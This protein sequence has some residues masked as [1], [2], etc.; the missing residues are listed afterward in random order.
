MSNLIPLEPP[1]EEFQLDSRQQL[2]VKGLL[3][4]GAKE[5]AEAYKA[6]SLILSSPGF[7]SAVCLVAHLV[8]DI[9]N[10]LPA[11]S[12]I[13]VSA[14]FDYREALDDLARECERLGLITVPNT[15][16]LEGESS[17]IP[18]NYHPVEDEVKI[19]RH[20]LAKLWDLLCK[21]RSVGDTHGWRLKEMVRKADREQLPPSNPVVSS[22]GTQ[23]KAIHS[24]AQSE[25]HLRGPSVTNERDVQECRQWFKEL[26]DILF[27]L[28][29]SFYEPVEE[30][31]EILEDTNA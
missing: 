29:S 25:A 22:I 3:T 30:L 28:L 10:R 31:D 8:R 5:L 16:L 27:S 6:A 20:I 4:K 14:R 15:E 13:P 24:W 9:I 7:P 2:I 11:Y 12:D 17:P 19:P 1:R 21:H 23:L 18:D 26:E